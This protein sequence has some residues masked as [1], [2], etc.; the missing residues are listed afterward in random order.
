MKN[1]VAKL[2]V[3]K[4]AFEKNDARV[5]KECSDCR[6]ILATKRTTLKNAEASVKAA[7]LKFKAVNVR[8]VIE[9]CDKLKKL[10]Q[11][12]MYVYVYIYIHVFK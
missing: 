9:Y 5:S 12:H 1:D 8:S 3:Q 2:K 6:N 10:L 11:F 7:D 4:E